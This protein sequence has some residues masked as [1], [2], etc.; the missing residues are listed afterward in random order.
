VGWVMLSNIQI[1]SLI[2]KGILTYIPTILRIRGE[3]SLEFPYLNFDNDEVQSNCL[4]DLS[5]DKNSV[6][7]LI[8]DGPQVVGVSAGFPL[9]KK[10]KNIRQPFL[11]KKYNLQEIFYLESSALLKKYHN[12][13][14]G[15]YFFDIRE[16]H[17]KNLRYKKTCFYNVIPNENHH[18]YQST[19]PFFEFHWKKRGYVEH[20]DLVV[21]NKSD[22]SQNHNYYFWVKN[23]N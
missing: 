14:I 15:H 21:V 8:F 6:V 10:E 12:R 9:E 7:I 16:N 19:N 5:E 11:E 22:K 1:M 23:I 4:R 17:A 18:N 3:V 2:G 20:K 13:G